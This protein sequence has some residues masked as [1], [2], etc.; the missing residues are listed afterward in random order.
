VVVA[1][2]AAGDKVT[3][4]AWAA[5]L[6]QWLPALGV[7]LAVT[8]LAWSLRAY[9]PFS[10]GVLAGA[11]GN[12]ATSATELS[13]AARLDPTNAFFWMQSGYAHGR[14]AL[15]DMGHVVDQTEAA[16]AINDYQRGIALEPELA[17]NYANLG[18][19]LLASGGGEAG[20]AALEEA[21]ARAELEPGFRATLAKAYE[22]A[23]RTD[24]AAA[25]FQSA[26]DLR[27]DWAT[28]Y[29]FR[30]TPVRRQALAEWQMRH[31]GGWRP[32]GAELAPGWEA[33][34]AGKPAQAITAFQAVTGP[35]RPEAY[36]GL[37]LA[38][39]AEG[40]APEAERALRTSLFVPGAAGQIT[41]M[42]RFALGRSLAAQ[43]RGAEA[44][45]AYEAGLA[46]LDGTTSF[47]V[48]QL[49]ASDYGWYVFHRES[50]P[51]DLL[52]GIEAFHYPAS[53]VEAMVALGDLAEQAGQPVSALEWF[54][55][56]AFAAPDSAAATARAAERGGC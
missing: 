19:L 26:L 13:V 16:A 10:R 1:L 12:W 56:A 51:P 33:L 43:G 15:D 24:A 45:S 7:A 53:A 39:L 44:A 36:L 47:G 30:A 28:A 5:R 18:V 11:L 54:C 8:A 49:G 52:P 22:A 32:G 2:L 9:A 3:Q 42:T 25:E 41:A 34:A 50:L 21:V 37:G 29:F 48:G 14:V 27:P 6:S 38:H 35:N 17:T 55:R 40:Q 23:G 20:I 46:L 4:R 31:P